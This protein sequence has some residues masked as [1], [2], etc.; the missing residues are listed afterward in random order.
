VT[1]SNA[2][3]A[4]VASTTAMSGPGSDGPS[5][6]SSRMTASVLAATASVSQSVSVATPRKPRTSATI[7]PP[8]KEVP[9]TLPSWPTTIS[10]APPAR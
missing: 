5:Q 6:R 10:T 8:S 4:T 9:I 3:D 7:V 1:R 2:T